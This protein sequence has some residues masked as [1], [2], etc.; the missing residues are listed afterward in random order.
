[1]KTIRIIEWKQEFTALGGFYFC[2][3]LVS[4]LPSPKKCLNETVFYMHK[5]SINGS[6]VILTT[7]LCKHHATYHNKVH[8]KTIVVY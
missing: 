3:N 1:M 6:K 4:T 2:V 7:S 8:F 5:E